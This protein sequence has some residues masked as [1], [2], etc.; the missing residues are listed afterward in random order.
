[1][2]RSRLF[3]PL[4][5]AAAGLAAC[6][7]DTVDGDKVEMEIEQ[8]LS[9]AT[10]EIASVSCPADVEEKEGA[11]F[12]CDAELAGGGSA[13][14]TVTQQENNEFTYQAK[15]GSVRIADDSLEPYLEQRLAAQGVGA[16][17]DCPKLVNVKAGESA[18]CGAMTAGGRQADLTFTWEDAAGSVDS[19]SVETSGG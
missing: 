7:S 8:Q 12:S 14:I 2:R 9:T 3:L 10:A 17:V 16:E 6:G 11:K 18:T 15:D 13:V 19:S 5:L 1:M 4:L